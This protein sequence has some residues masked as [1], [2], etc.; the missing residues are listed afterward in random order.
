MTRAAPLILTLLICVVGGMVFVAA[1]DSNVAQ[2]DDSADPVAFSEGPEDLDGASDGAGSDFVATNDKVFP[3]IVRKLS[4][5][6]LIELHGV[7]PQGRTGQVACSTCHSIREPN[8]ENV[9]AE[10]LDEFH[11]RMTFEHGKITCYAC[12]DPKN[13]DALRLADGKAIG[14]EEAMVLCSQCHASQATA[15]A[16]GAHGGMNGFWDLS[17]GPQLKNNC[18]DCHDPHSPAF[19]KMI[20]GFKPRDRFNEPSD[21]DLAHPVG[22]SHDEE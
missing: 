22:D 12:H 15:F 9:T 10:T 13:A 6:P 20:V 17:R 21:H 19:P 4:G 1:T 16:H 14:F 18:I 7:D 11:Q 2:Q 5:P 8:F 3:V